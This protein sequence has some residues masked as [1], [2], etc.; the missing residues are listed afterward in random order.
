MTLDQ[1]P[2]QELVKILVEKYFYRKEYFSH[3][4]ITQFIK[5]IND[6]LL[7]KYSDKVK[8]NYLIE[9]LNLLKKELLKNN[10]KDDVN[11]SDFKIIIRNRI[12]D[13]LKL[14]DLSLME[15]SNQPN[16]DI[17]Q[18][19]I[20]RCYYY[21]DEI[22]IMSEY[23]EN[24]DLSKGKGEEFINMLISKSKANHILLKGINKRFHYDLDD[25]NDNQSI[26]SFSHSLNTFYDELAIKL[27]NIIKDGAE[28]QIVMHLY[29]EGDVI[30]DEDKIE[31]F[32]PYSP[33]NIKKAIKK[34]LDNKV[35]N[36]KTWIE[37]IEQ[38]KQKYDENV[39]DIN[40]DKL[41]REVTFGEY[42]IQ[43][44]N[45][46][47]II[48]KRDLIVQKLKDVSLRLDD[49]DFKYTHKPDIKNLV[50]ITSDLTE[51]RIRLIDCYNILL[52][53]DFIEECHPIIFRSLFEKE[54]FIAPVNWIGSN[55][56]LNYFIIGIVEVFK[57]NKSFWPEVHRCFIHN[58]KPFGKDSIRSYG[59]KGKPLSDNTI[60]VLDKAINSIV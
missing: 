46:F 14:M 45:E 59:G 51:L 52:K 40:F 36:L 18:E 8:S 33:K 15:F 50:L 43:D 2:I 32:D 53:G 39:E 47:I 29:V 58:G 10:L 24:T 27:T 17:M 19:I 3:R 48:T 57:D 23:F 34:L 7:V 44:N 4:E 20:E 12:T 55:K 54:K 35:S 42:K 9:K 25:E 1:F 21:L 38:I 37:E 22:S 28:E 26:D 41:L 5:E 60:L 31:E 49:Y 56:E 6:E 30:P 11:I 16:I 13:C